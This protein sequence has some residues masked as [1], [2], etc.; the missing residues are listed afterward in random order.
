MKHRTI[1]LIFIFAIISFFGFMYSATAVYAQTP[2]GTP[3]ETQEVTETATL[4]PELI[5]V[6]QR[7]FAE[8]I[9]L[10]QA[11][12]TIDLVTPT[13][14]R[15]SAIKEGDL[16]GEVVLESETQY[17]VL[18]VILVGDDEILLLEGGIQI[19]SEAVVLD[20]ACEQL[21]RLEVK[22]EEDLD[23]EDEEAEMAIEEGLIWDLQDVEDLVLGIGD[24]DVDASSGRLDPDVAD[25][26]YEW[27][28]FATEE[29]EFAPELVA[30]F[31]Q[32]VRDAR[33]SGEIPQI[34]ER[35]LIRFMIERIDLALDNLVWYGLGEDDQN[36]LLD[37]YGGR[38][39]EI[40]YFTT[41]IVEV[42]SEEDGGEI[43]EEEILTFVEGWIV[44]D[45]IFQLLEQPRVFAAGSEGE[46]DF[47]GEFEFEE[48]EKPLLLDETIQSVVMTT[49]FPEAEGVVYWI[50]S[51]RTEFGYE[52]YA[53]RASWDG[54]DYVVEEG[55]HI[56][57]PLDL[58]N[59]SY[60]LGYM[61]EKAL[62]IEICVDEWCV[63]GEVDFSAQTE[64][65]E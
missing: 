41:E 31:E 45:A 37:V 24:S 53:F 58:Y 36:Y 40:L 50:E 27:L 34:V 20:G 19:D 22:S 55:G 52:V 9:C 62:V 29:E 57:L 59:V 65:I 6:P 35:A 46:L 64:E 56:E 30:A 47:E 21:L 12:P 25:T 51:V 61:H 26:L 1:A 14:T 42:A 63:L 54:L 3:T 13:A 2:S 23:A 44:D 18:L 4:D 10:A 5:L 11:I 15:I 48:L 7:E 60:T 38:V 43:T 33:G 8:D 16:A 32:I 39:P 28:L 17:P 49:F